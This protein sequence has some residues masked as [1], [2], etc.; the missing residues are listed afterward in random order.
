MYQIIIL[1]QAQRD[2]DQ[3]HSKTFQVL[4][5]K[6]IQLAA[7]PRPHGSIKLTNDEGYR[8]RVGDY[9]LLHRID[10]KAK[11]IFLYRVKHRREAYR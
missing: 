2:L 11:E 6:I 5:N 9:R 10:D 3:F 1:S 7:D 4:K 8:M